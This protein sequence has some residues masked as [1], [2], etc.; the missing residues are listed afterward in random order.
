MAVKNNNYFWIEF[1]QPNGVVSGLTNDYT[2]MYHSFDG[3]TWETTPNTLSMG[4]NT[5]VYFRNDSKKI[6]DG[7][8]LLKIKF[9]SNARVGGDISSITDMANYC[10]NRL[11]DDNTFL[12]DASELILPWSTL[13]K[14]CYNGMFAY[15]TSLVTAPA[16]PAT[17]LANG[18]YYSMFI[19]CASLLNAPALPVTTL[20]DSCYNSMFIGCTSLTTAPELP[21]TTLAD[22]CYNSMFWGCTSLVN[23]PALPATTLT[24]DC[25][26]GMFNGCTSLTA[27][28]ALPATTLAE[29][30]Y[31]YMFCD[32][33]SLT[34][35]PELPATTLAKKCYRNMFCHCTSLTAAPELPATTLVSQCYEYMFFNCTSLNYIKML[36]TDISAG[37]CLF[38]WVE[39]VASTG[40]FVKHPDN[41]TITVDVNGI[42]EGWTVY[43]EG[44]PNI[45]EPEEPTDP[46]NPNPPVDPDTPE[47]DL[48]Q[49][50]FWVEFE[51][52]GGTINIGTTGAGAATGGTYSDLRYSFDGSSWSA[53]TSSIKMDT[54]T[55]VFI[56]NDSGKMNNGAT[57]S[58]GDYKAEN[59]TFTKNAKIG[60]LLSTL[61]S[62]NNLCGYKLFY[63]NSY[64]TDAS[65]LVL[66]NESLQGSCYSMMFYNC[67]NLTSTPALPATTLAEGCYA[68]MFY[69]C[70]SLITAPALPATT[71]AESC[72]TN[73]FQKCTSL[74]TAPELPATNVANRC[75]ASMFFGCTS[76]K[77]I[78]SILPATTLVGACYTAMFYGCSSITTAPILPA[79]TLT[80][81]NKNSSYIGCYYEMFYGCSKLNYIEMLGEG[82]I[83]WHYTRNWVRNVAPTG[84]FI[85]SD[86]VDIAIDSY[87]GIPIGWTVYNESDIEDPDNPGGGGGEDPDN[88]GGGGGEDPDNPGGG[89]GED[90]DNPGGGGGEDPDNPGGGGGEDPDPDLPDIP[91]TPV[92]PEEPLPPADPDTEPTIVVS[93][94]Q[95]ILDNVG[96]SNIIQV[97]YV[98]VDEITL[99]D[100]GDG[101]TIEEVE[102]VI[103]NQGIQI[104]YKITRVSPKRQNVQISFNGKNNSNG[105]TGTSNK[106]T[107][108]GEPIPAT[109]NITTIWPKKGEYFLIEDK[110]DCHID[111]TISNF[112][113]PYTMT[114]SIKDTNGAVYLRNSEE[115]ILD[116]DLYLTY[117][118]KSLANNTNEPFTGTIDFT[119]TDELTNYNVSIPFYVAY[120]NE[121]EVRVNVN[122]YNF[123][124]DGN[125]LDT[126]K[127]MFIDAHYIKIAS[128]NDPVVDVDWFHLEDGVRSDYK[129]WVN[130]EYVVVGDSYRHNFTI[131]ANS[132]PARKG[133]ITF[134]GKGIDGKDYSFVLDI[135][136]EGSDTEKPIDEG[137]IELLQL[138]VILNASGEEQT[139][140]VKYYD[141]Q[142]I[143]AP[144]L[145]GTWATVTEVSRTEPMDDV[146]WNGEE[147]QSVIVTYKA[148]AQST[149][150]GRQMKVKFSSDI[151]YYDGGTIYMEKDK[152]IIYQLAEGSTEVQGDVVILR[153]ST[154]FTY[155]GTPTGWDFRV[156]Y[157]DVTP[158]TPTISES[159]CRIA[160][161]RDLT[162]KDYDYY[163]EYILDVD[164]NE[165][166]VSRSCTITFIGNCE[167]GTQIK[168]PFRFT[169]EGQEEIFNEGEYANY[170][171]YFKDI[172]G[173][174][175]SVSFITNPR[176][177][178]Y[179][180][181]RLA[182]DNPVVVS[183]SET[184]NLYEPIRTS[185]CTIK[186]VSSHYLMNL[187]TG[188]AQGTQVILRN[189][190]RNTVEWCGY[191][192]PNLYNQGFSSPV[193][194]IE[195]EASDCLA[196]L[197]YFEYEYYFQGNG[198]PM[199][200]SFKDIVD[201]IADR[202]GLIQDYRFTQKE[203]SNSDTT[204][205]FD[206]KEFYI[207]ENN[208]YSEEGEPWTYQ[209]VLEE[210]CKYFGFVCFQ[211]G[212]SL[213]F[214]DYDRYKTTKDMVGYVYSKADRW[215]TR[216]YRTLSS[217]NS[218]TEDS[219]RG[220]GGSMSLDDIFNKVS[221]NCNY[222]NVEHII[223][224][225]FEDDFLTERN[226]TTITTV[227][228]RG[229]EI[230][231]KTAYNVYDHKNIK[232]HFYQPIIG[233]N[234][235]EV[236]V[237]PTEEQF[238][239][240][241]FFKDFVGGNIVDLYH[242]GYSDLKG[243]TY[244]SKEWERFL[245]ISQLNRPWCKGPIAYEYDTT[246]YWEDY[247]LPI[248]EFTQLPQIFIDNHKE[249]Y[250]DR[251]PTT[252]GRVPST[253]A[254]GIGTSSTTSRNER[255]TV[256]PVKAEHYFVISAEAAFTPDFDESFVPEGVEEK[257]FNKW[258]NTEY[259][260]YTFDLIKDTTS[261]DTAFAPKLTFYLEIPTEG[262]WNGE[263][264]V[265][266][267]TWFE[268]PLEELEYKKDVWYSFKNTQN[269]VQ[270]NLFLGKAGYKIPLPESVESTAFMQFKI[271][272]PK[273]FAHCA[274]G[275]DNG[276]AGNAY[277]LIKDLQMDIVTRNSSLLKDEDIVYEN[278]IDD[279]NVIDGPE[280][281][282]KITSDNNITHSYS[283][284]ST[285]YGDD[286]INTT[287]FRFYDKDGELI[288]PEEAIIEKYV[289]QYSTPSLKENVVLDLTFTPSQLITDTYWN[290]DFVIVAQEI[291]YKMCSQTITLLQKK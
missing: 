129:D 6:S 65:E 205:I 81:E 70:T 39:Y 9:N 47:E 111:F 163:K 243:S 192:Q 207:S 181:I 206:F 254:S 212:E 222:Y 126:N 288:L 268:V 131:D 278:V 53:A 18:C 289:K 261:K 238:S 58:I 154:T 267:E 55:L 137:Y 258:S 250:G 165:S 145:G 48:K 14:G 158:D 10:C 182:G 41:T 132:G 200:V 275:D 208:F 34:T 157:K 124:K 225:I 91:D 105:K 279:N 247:N 82:Y 80:Y 155:Y 175:H 33:T 104:T 237:E 76:L 60:G 83:D 116:P 96:D 61:V 3:S 59:I 125:R 63:G 219:Y 173:T 226:K 123:D 69:G 93:K 101:F 38:H 241:T 27:A 106:V 140:Q 85:K 67:T 136:Q 285:K 35:A 246:K 199:I 194:E 170:K 13:V 269:T 40:T 228:N 190:D 128:I 8:L 73:M 167:D 66:H 20:A 198:Q 271:G 251:V 159:W 2:D 283:T 234:T 201:S 78:P 211:W 259:G 249:V 220:T 107:L 31:Y 203:F 62:M 64:L 196:G 44:D 204:K 30:C 110:Q 130:G 180:D 142:T 274:L 255:P 273:R 265:D 143:H 191:L 183:Y 121:G 120:A 17:T 109:V 135:N 216:T 12:T 88:P 138:S 56:Q 195:F 108:R 87:D 169:Q 257:G 236:E 4:S 162:D 90:P 284:V 146:A 45:P 25:Y 74:I 84:T 286:M 94:N 46:D 114:Y 280:I 79:K 277:C 133:T 160:E 242:L 29:D 42:P 72:Y 21:A 210:T 253:K 50:Y 156:G 209:E 37:D 147:C 176:S 102:R 122:S 119:Y 218:I 230:G 57:A 32:C 43:N 213:Y 233:T 149:T 71:L 291:D 97:T 15:C 290:K 113:T 117:D 49:Q 215:R 229:Q 54:N 223:P 239:S 270:T 24:S 22:G 174:L 232:S 152:F 172:E 202:C 188:K 99:P 118:F 256:N 177:D 262:W 139:F 26:S 231:S 260:G 184:D 100:V 264:W 153:Y 127:D 144:E 7:T 272:M 282:L 252:G 281:D 245:M 276:E 189:E 92:D 186:V 148:T 52:T 168:I 287:N 1:E 161:V 193:E 103:T 248:M 263:K 141:A 235:H 214:I 178:T 68:S 16:L 227:V 266:Y 89:G 217:S 151:N 75:Y 23:V 185:N 77:N 197:Q 5:L 224:D 166:P 19:G 244:E 221:V 95:I 240:K 51:E 134:S 86:N 115:T 11:F 171:G 28:P 98:G 36:A 179:G 164:T 150:S 187:Y 112:N